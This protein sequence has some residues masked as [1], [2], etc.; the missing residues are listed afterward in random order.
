MKKGKWTAGTT[1]PLGTV[2]LGSGSGTQRVQ[3]FHCNIE[4]ICGTINSSR[5]F[6]AIGPSKKGKLLKQ[7]RLAA[8]RRGIG[9]ALASVI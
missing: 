5:C 3:G 4:A 1:N 7:A 6:R 2:L 9:H 8:R